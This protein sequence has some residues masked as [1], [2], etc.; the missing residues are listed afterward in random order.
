MAAIAVANE[1]RAIREKFVGEQCRHHWVI[2]DAAGR[3]SDGVC[4]FCGAHKAFM[5]YLP[6]CLQA[7]EE[8]YEAWLKR[9]RDYMRGRELED[10]EA[11]EVARV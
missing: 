7:D 4:K 8:E 11:L 6:D 1:E 10:E 3:A 9:Q 5:N 2:E